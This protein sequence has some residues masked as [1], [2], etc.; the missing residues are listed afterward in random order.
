[1]QSGS[2]KATDIISHQVVNMDSIQVRKDNN[3][4]KFM[5]FQLNNDFTVGE[6]FQSE[7]IDNL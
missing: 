6:F 5:D 4:P 7:T 2:F 3:V 1:M